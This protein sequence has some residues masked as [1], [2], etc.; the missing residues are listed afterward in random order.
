[1]FWSTRRA[2]PSQVFMA[3][4]LAHVEEMILRECNF[5][6]ASLEESKD[7]SVRSAVAELRRS[8][9]ENGE[10]TLRDLCRSS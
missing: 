7:E 6:I 8:I 10:F 1:M 9:H 4:F 2:P 3:L 5:A